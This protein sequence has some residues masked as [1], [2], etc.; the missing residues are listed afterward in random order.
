MLAVSA[1]GTL[2]AKDSIEVRVLVNPSRDQNE[3]LQ[4]SP[5]VCLVKI[6]L[7]FPPV[8]PSMSLLRTRNNE[9]GGCVLKAVL[10]S[11]LK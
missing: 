3:T 6:D 8:D 2:Q 10:K 1:L 9:F 4:E 5:L 11:L 7:A